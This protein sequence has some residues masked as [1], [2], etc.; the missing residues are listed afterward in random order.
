MLPGADY[1][2]ACKQQTDFRSSPLSLR[3]EI[4]LRFAFFWLASFESEI[5]RVIYLFYYFFYLPFLRLMHDWCMG[6]KR[7]TPRSEAYNPDRGSEGGYMFLPRFNT[8][9]NKARLLNMYC[10]DIAWEEIYTCQNRLKTA[11]VEEKLDIV[12]CCSFYAT[13]AID[14]KA[15]FEQIWTVDYRRCWSLPEQA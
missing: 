7:Q 15:S 10:L 4:C 8:A 9:Q 2:V 5:V 13:E 12:S 3:P 11:K 1:P 14:L 6:P